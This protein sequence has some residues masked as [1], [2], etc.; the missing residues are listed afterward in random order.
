MER[1]ADTDARDFGSVTLAAA[2]DALLII[3][4]RSGLVESFLR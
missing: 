1:L 2:R 3:E 4:E